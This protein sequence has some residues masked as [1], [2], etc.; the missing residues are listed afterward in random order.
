MYEQLDED[1]ASM[2]LLD[3]VEFQDHQRKNERA[4]AKAT[5]SLSKSDTRQDSFNEQEINQTCGNYFAAPV[6]GITRRAS[7]QMVSH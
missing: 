5:A 6:V 3:F 7:V 2:D 1:E 4:Q